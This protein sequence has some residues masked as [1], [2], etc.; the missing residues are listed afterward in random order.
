MG[1]GTWDIIYQ[2]CIEGGINSL[3]CCN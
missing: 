3:W 2:N 1:L